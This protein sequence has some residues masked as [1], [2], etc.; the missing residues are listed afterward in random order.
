MILLERSTHGSAAFCFG[1]RSG[2]NASK[3]KQNKKESEK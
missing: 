2:E 1:H 3:I